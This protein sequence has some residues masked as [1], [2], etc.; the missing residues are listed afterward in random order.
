IDQVS[1]REG[2]KTTLTTI[3]RVL[4]D[5]PT[6]FVITAERAGDIRTPAD[7]IRSRIF[8]TFSLLGSRRFYSSIFKLFP[9]A[10]LLDLASQENE[11]IDLL[12]RLIPVLSDEILE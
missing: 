2:A 12:G 3:G 5:L 6:E 4:K 1:L 11:A 9:D 10:R 7:F 8:I